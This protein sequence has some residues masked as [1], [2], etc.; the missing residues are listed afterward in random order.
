MLNVTNH[1]G[2]ANRNHNEI[3][4]HTCLYDYHQ[5]IRNN[6]CWQGC[7][8]K[9]TLVHSWWEC[10]LVQTVWKIAWSFLKR[11]KLGLPYDPAISLLCICTKKMKTLTPKDIC[12]PMFITELFTIV[13]T[14]EQLQCSLMGEWLKKCDTH[15]G[16]LLSH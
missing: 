1:Q 14:W 9:E 15:T 5:K 13:E 8:E 2:N 11:S 7:G 12:T 3:S 6:K 16:I 10:K 4:L